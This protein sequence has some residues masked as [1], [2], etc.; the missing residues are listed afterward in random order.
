MV[1]LE[2]GITNFGKLHDRKISFD[3]GMNVIYGENEAGKTTV[4]SFIRAMLFGLD[5]QRGRASRTDDYSKYEP[6]ESPAAYEGTLRF[7][8]GRAVYR[9]YRR[10]SRNDRRTEIINETTGEELTEEM[11]RELLGGVTESSFMN[12]VC[13]SQMKAAPGQS[14]SDELRNSMV[15][16]L[17]AGEPEWD[18]KKAFTFLAEEKKRLMKNY[19]PKLEE[20]LKAAEEDLREVEEELLQQTMRKEEAE[21]ELEDL[22]REIQRERHAYE[23]SA[24]R[25][26]IMRIE[27]MFSIVS[28]LIMV[29]CY[30]VGFWKEGVWIFGVLALSSGF[31]AWKGHTLTS[32]SAAFMEAE[33]KEK[34]MSEQIQKVEW[35]L[36]QMK[37]RAVIYESG[38]ESCRQQVEENRRLYQ[39]ISA[40]ILA[41]QTLKQV[42]LSMHQ[43]VSE[44]LRGRMSELLS[45]I[46][47]GRYSRILIQEKGEIFLY[48]QERRIPL[49]QL[50]RGTLEQ[51]Y[52]ALRLAAADCVMGYETLPLLFDETFVY[53]DRE[54]LKNALAV[55]AEQSRQILL[56]TCH[57]REGEILEDMKKNFLLLKL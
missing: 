22:R 19:Q 3:K 34:A 55:L 47:A 35:K 24:K 37:E 14:L 21:E 48:E 45:A 27:L 12:T 6:W 32:V 26:R 31:L 50:S 52:L 36:E 18:M 53:Y 46:T 54:R 40:I 23:N 8:K 57:S 1:I 41:E 16:Y 25:K 13:I 56:F 15:N 9:I 49:Y 30:V 28:F 43:N 7:Q 44:Q 38:L 11:L 42:T 39:Q 4:H 5:R 51:V 20:E 2:V 10:F 29:F 17:S 33:K